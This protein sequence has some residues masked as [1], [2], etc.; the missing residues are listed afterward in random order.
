VE[1]TGRRVAASYESG[2]EVPGSVTGG[3]CLSDC[4]RFKKASSPWSALSRSCR[5]QYGS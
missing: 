1:W 2:N 3:E 5:L 4:Q